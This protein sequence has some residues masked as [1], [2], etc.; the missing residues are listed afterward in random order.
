[1]ALDTSNLLSRIAGPTAAASGTSTLFTPTASHVYTVK[2]IKVVNTD[3]VNS[4][5]FQLFVG[6]SAAANAVTALFTVDA[7]GYA[8]SDEFLVLQSTGDTLQVTTSATGL[9]FSVYALDQS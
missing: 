1:M 3:T 4:K 9:T 6:G 5:T 7:G 2:K 8:E